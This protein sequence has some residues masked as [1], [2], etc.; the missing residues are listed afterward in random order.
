MH[1]RF[2]FFLFIFHLF[3][4]VV[5]NYILAVSKHC[6]HIWEFPLQR[7]ATKKKTKNF[8]TLKA[9]SR[10]YEIEMYNKYNNVN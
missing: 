4:V 5:I 10:L 8:I 1:E 2:L 3:V 7:S 6:V 9:Y